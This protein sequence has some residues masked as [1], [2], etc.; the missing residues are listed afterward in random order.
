MAR[1]VRQI[2]HHTLMGSG[3][4]PLQWLDRDWLSVLPSEEEKCLALF[5]SVNPMVAQLM[6]RRAPSLSW[7]LR[8][9]LTE[10]QVLLPEVPHKVI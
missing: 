1:W 9:T 4:D 8:A 6:L 7:L 5:P 10:L 3:R 2:S